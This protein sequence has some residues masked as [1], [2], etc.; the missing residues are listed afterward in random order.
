MKI[1][2][3]FFALL[4]V[5]VAS[6]FTRPAVTPEAPAAAV[7]YFLK[8]EGVDGESADDTHKGWIEINSYSLDRAAQ[9]VQIARNKTSRSSAKLALFCAKGTHIKKAVLHVR[10]S[11][12]DYMKIE[13][14][15]VLIT[16][17]Q[18]S[19]SSSG[20]PTESFSLNFTKVTF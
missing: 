14:E 10:K 6:S 19:S 4:L 18:T 16:S 11:G 8:I 3:P 15:N 17:Y 5:V 1:L 20:I 7:D 9:K 13:L 12:G 2:F